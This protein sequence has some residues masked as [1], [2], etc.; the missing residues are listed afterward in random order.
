MP[1]FDKENYNFTNLFFNKYGKHITK[2]VFAAANR[3]YV[4]VSLTAAAS[5]SYI[6]R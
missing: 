1:V 6:I 4:L 5:D 2:M 3:S